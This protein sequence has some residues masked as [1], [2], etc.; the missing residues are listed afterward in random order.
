MTAVGVRPF[1]GDTL[2]E[3]YYHEAEC[4]DDSRLDEWLGLLTADVDY[5]VPIR[6]VRETGELATNSDFTNRG[7]YLWED[8]GTLRTR[9]V[10]LDSEF[11]WA[12]RPATRTRRL[13]TNIRRR[14]LVGGDPDTETRVLT[15]IAV[16][17]YK[18]DSPDPVILTG[19][20][21][22]V[23]RVVDGEF[24]LARRVVRLDANVLGLHSLSIFL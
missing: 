16:Y 6:V 24:R 11:A 21:D 4:L 22:D 23:L 15:N 8:Y 12:E 18:R 3:F 9:I 20:R 10:R 5:R 19:E 7:H 14:D 2:T 13:V 1:T 17:A